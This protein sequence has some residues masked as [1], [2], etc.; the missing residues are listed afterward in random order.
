[1]NFSPQQIYDVDNNI[2]GKTIYMPEYQAVSIAA[3]GASEGAEAV[4]P[5]F[6]P[7]TET[8]QLAYGWRYP[9]GTKGGYTGQDWR[10]CAC[11]NRDYGSN[12]YQI[13]N[14]KAYCI[15]HGCLEQKLAQLEEGG[16]LF[17]DST[18]PADAILKI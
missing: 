3:P 5:F 17:E 11:C 15:P 9:V 10:E 8:P 16:P 13:I 7:E 12:S 2:E 6:D 4:F 14:G 18:I 1:M